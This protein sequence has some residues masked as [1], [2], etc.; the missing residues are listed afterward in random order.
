MTSSNVF[1]IDTARDTGLEY[2]RNRFVQIPNIKSR[3]A[4]ILDTTNF[5]E[6]MS[7]SFLHRCYVQNGGKFEAKTRRGTEDYL[8]SCLPFCAEK[9]FIPNTA[10]IVGNKLNLWHPHPV[11]ASGNVVSKEDVPLYIEF[12]ERLFPLAEERRF[13]HWWIAHTVVR[14]ERKIV[15]TPVLRSPQGTGKSFLTETL[16]FSLMGRNAAVGDLDQITGQFQDFVVGKT[17]IALDE[18]YCDKKR[19]VDALKVFQSNDKVLINQKHKAAYSIDNFVNFI[20]N[21]NDYDPVVFESHD[22]RFF[23]PQYIEHRENAA[24]TQQFIERFAHWITKEGGAQ[25]IRDF[26]ESINLDAYN[27]KAP[28]PMTAS[29][30]ARIGYNFEDRLIQAVEDLIANAEVVKTTDVHNRLLMMDNEFSNI[31][32]RKVAATLEQCGCLIKKTTNCNYQITPLGKSRGLS[33]NTAPKVLEERTADLN[34]F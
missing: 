19:T 26:L 13:M 18:V 31:K 25:M 23:I 2:I 33:A 24:E 6:D 10:Q 4:L 20:I 29:K 22:R 27:P 32:V 9:V 34:S 11:N 30:Q 21:S 1:N 3:A 8:V 28:A 14:P 15:A 12:M 5:V 16:L 17:L 7:L